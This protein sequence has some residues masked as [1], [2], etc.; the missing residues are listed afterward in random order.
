MPSD[1]VAGG[2][3]SGLADFY[4]FIGRTTGQE[5]DLKCIERER[6]K[7]HALLSQNTR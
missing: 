6:P 1:T 3:S 4:R 7:M 5:L 2:W